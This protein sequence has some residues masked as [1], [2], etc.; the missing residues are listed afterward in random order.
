M[1]QPRVRIAPSPTG[2]LHV[3]T[4][5]T[6]L[7]NY[8]FAKQGGGA[9]VL[10]IEDTDL[11]RSEMRFEKDIFDELAWLGIEPNES[12][13]TG[14]PY[15]PYRQSERTATYCPHIERLLAEGKAFYCFHTQDELEA[16]K[17]N[18]LYEKR[19]PIHMCE[20][21][22]MDVKEAE[23]LKDTKQSYVIRF[24]TPAG[25]RILFRDLIRGELE[26]LTDIL[27]DFSIAKRVEV[28]L[29]HFAVVVDDYEMKITHVIRGE[30]HLPNTPKHILLNEALGFPQPLYAHV[31]LIL[32]P[33]RSKLSKR[34]GATAITE[35]REMG[36]LPEALINFLGLLGWNPGI[37]RELFSL[38]EL[39][40]EF[41]LKGV[42]KSGA[43]FDFQK[44]DWMNGEYIRKKSVAELTDLCIPYFKSSLGVSTESVSRVFL[45]AMVSLEQ[46][47]LKK[48]SEIGEKT[49]YFFSAPLYEKKLLYW[50]K[51]TTQEVA[52][53]LERADKVLA[54]ISTQTSK[55]EIEAAFFLEIGEDDKGAILWPVRVALTG[56]K[57]SPGPFEIIAVIG[58]DEAQNRLA[59]AQALLQ[60][61]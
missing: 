52:Y 30:D 21:R 13:L 3:G 37:E 58:R 43:I 36:Y 23:V 7:F 14:G 17:K 1:S 29:Y 11:E 39:A 41:S 54:N 15:A 34:H 40:R 26:F 24:K 5:H 59:R 42:Q 12:P 45:E 8:L 25:R 56:R 20:F 9:M 33:D 61:E 57:A 49:S 44:L 38:D 18:L 19:P 6:A 31:S 50:K 46:P 60:K 10:R 4:A 27:G 55:L 51:Q 2:F 47:R 16:E 35:F 28:P 53:A 48:L 32:G 22:T